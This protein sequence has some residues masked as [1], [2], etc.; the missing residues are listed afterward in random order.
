MINFSSVSISGVFNYGR[1]RVLWK[2]GLLRVYTVDGLR[3]EITAE[4]PI[5]RSGYLNSWTVKTGKG[6]I[7]LRKKCLTCGGRRWWQLMY[8]SIDELWGIPL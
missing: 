6:D 4:K 8:K 3:L 7:V 2:D 1:S 5:L